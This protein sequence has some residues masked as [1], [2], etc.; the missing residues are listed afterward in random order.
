MDSLE[1]NDL[2]SKENNNPRQRPR[3]CCNHNILPCGILPQICDKKGQ[4]EMK[5]EMDKRAGRVQSVTEILIE[6][7]LLPEAADKSKTKTEND[8]A[9]QP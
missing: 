6:M 7:G 5:E 3:K 4:C 1:E 2:R 9:A 8:T